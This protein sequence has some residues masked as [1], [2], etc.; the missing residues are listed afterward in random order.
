VVQSVVSGD[1]T[2][3]MGEAEAA[4]VRQDTPLLYY[5]GGYSRLDR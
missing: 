3:F 4:S 1:H 5:R 2:I